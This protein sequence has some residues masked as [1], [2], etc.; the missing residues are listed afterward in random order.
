[1]SAKHNRWIFGICIICAAVISCG[2]DSPESPGTGTVVVR[3]IDSSIG[4]VPDVEVS[5]IGTNLVGK[6]DREGTVVF[7]PAGGSYFVDAAVCCA[8]AG[9]IEHHKR[10]RIAG[11]QTVKVELHACLVCV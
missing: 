4:P 2:D 1:M 6:T 10:V 8:G 9:M 3:V 5:L 11:G 7:H